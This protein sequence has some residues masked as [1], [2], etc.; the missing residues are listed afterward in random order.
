M[1]L[2]FFLGF[3]RPNLIIIDPPW[4]NPLMEKKMTKK[5]DS[6][7]Q[8]IIKIKGTVSIIHKIKTKMQIPYM[9][10]S[11]QHP[12]PFPREGAIFA[13]LVQNRRK[14]S[15]SGSALSTICSSH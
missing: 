11:Q 1:I 4:L 5:V 12:A 15:T 13:M 6:F 8:Q 7:S 10:P 9:L 14:T 2:S 3:R